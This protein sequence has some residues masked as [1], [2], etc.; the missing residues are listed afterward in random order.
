MGQGARRTFIIENQIFED[1]SGISY[2]E[3]A[4]QVVADLMATIHAVGGMLAV[5]A[6]RVELP[7][8]P[9]GVTLAETVGVVI[10]WKL[11]SPL[12][13][14]PADEPRAQELEEDEPE[15]FDRAE[16]GDEWADDAPALADEPD[17]SSLEAE[18]VPA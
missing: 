11:V 1:G 13:R 12:E 16:P 14:L 4:E 5:T 15:V 17:V 2:R 9:A 3:Q 10:E 18:G 7:G 8:A 6:R